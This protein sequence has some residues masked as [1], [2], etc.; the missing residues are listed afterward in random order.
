[1]IKFSVSTN[2]TYHYVPNP[3]M[4]HWEGKTLYVILAEKNA[5][6]HSNHEVTQS[7]PKS[8]ID[9]IWLA[10]FKCQGLKNKT[11]E[12]L[13]IGRDQ[14]DMTAKCNFAFWN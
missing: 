6:P 7:N 2:Q 13:Q 1:M 3:D 10:F 9:N 8:T 11:E 12:L 14:E 5:Y 4:I